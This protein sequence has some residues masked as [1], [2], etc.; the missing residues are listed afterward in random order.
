[1]EAEKKKDGV[2]RKR[3]LEERWE[4]VRRITGYIDSTKEGREKIERYHE[5]KIK[6]EERDRSKRFKKI[7]LIREKIRSK[8]RMEDREDSPRKAD[9]KRLRENK[10]VKNHNHAEWKQQVRYEDLLY[11]AGGGENAKNREN[12][13]EEHLKNPK[14]EDQKRRFLKDGESKKRR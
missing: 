6:L 1:M 10:E 13:G 12:P 9:W 2:K 8:D 4:L 5:R 7:A 11:P 14:I 3:M